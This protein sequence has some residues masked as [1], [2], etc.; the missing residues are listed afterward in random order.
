MAKEKMESL[1]VDDV[2]PKLVLLWRA[3]LIFAAAFVV[4]R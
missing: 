1:V 2:A 4:F 3:K